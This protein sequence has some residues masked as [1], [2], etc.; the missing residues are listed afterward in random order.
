MHPSQIDPSVCGNTLS[1]TATVTSVPGYPAKLKI[2]LT[3]AS[4][5]W[6]VRCFFAPRVIILHTTNK[7]D[8]LQRA[9]EFYEQELLRRGQRVLSDEQYRSSSHSIDAVVALLVHNEAGRMARSEITRQCYL[10]TRSRSQGEIARFFKNIA[11]ERIDRVGIERF[12]AHLSQQDIRAFT[13]KAYMVV[14]KKVLTTALH[15]EWIDRLPTF[16]QVKTQANPRGHFT[17]REYLTL[18][19]A[20]KRLRLD[21]QEPQGL[22]QTHRS[23]RGGIYTATAGVP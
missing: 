5:Y 10:M 14:L 13:V 21:Y 6:Q 7:R 16:P 8:A 15:Q 1:I 12:M 9:K 11:V 22:A 2:F 19:R 17:V 4:R 3:N 18:L 20:A 23:T